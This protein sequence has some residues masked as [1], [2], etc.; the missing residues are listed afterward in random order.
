MRWISYQQ[1]NKAGGIVLL[2]HSPYGLLLQIY[3]NKWVLRHLGFRQ[4]MN[5]LYYTHDWIWELI[6][7][8]YI[9]IWGQWNPWNSLQWQTVIDYIEVIHDR[10]FNLTNEIISFIWWCSYKADLN[11]S[12]LFS[13]GSCQI[14]SK[15]LADC[16]TNHNTN[17]VYTISS[18]QANITIPCLSLCLSL[19]IYHLSH[20]V[21]YYCCFKLGKN[22]LSNYSVTVQ[23][24]SQEIGMY[25]FISI[26]WKSKCFVIQ[27]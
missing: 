22:P 1:W 15:Y 25:F 14:Q 27:N 8:S 3:K 13:A 18:V 10:S 12:R 4:W 24:F 21:K 26:S 23:L 6:F 20:S 2:L 11:W 7:W 9:I 16:A 5:T 19:S 17:L